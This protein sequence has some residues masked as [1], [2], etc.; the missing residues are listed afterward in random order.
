MTTTSKKKILIVGAGIAGLS[1]ARLC[2]RLN[3]AF[4]L[5]EKQPQLRVTGAGI[6]LPANA[7]KALRYLG[8]GPEID[9]EA[10]Q[11]KTIFYTK[12][13]GRILST[14]SL[15]EPPL[16]LDHFVAL[17]R[18]KLQEILIND[19][20]AKIHFDTTVTALTPSPNGLRVEFNS[21]HLTQEEYQAVIGADGL[22]SHI[23]ELSFGP[24][25]LVDLG[26]TNWRW[27]SA[28][29]TENLQPT[30]MLGAQDLFMAYPISSNSVYCYAH[31]YDPENK[32][33]Q[34]PDPQTLL[35]QIFKSYKGV[36]REFLENLPD[37]EALIPGRLRSVPHPFY[38]KGRVALVGDAGNA[39]SPMLQQ[40]AAC[41]LEDIIVLGELLAAFKTETALAYYEHYRKE[42]VDWIVQA[43]DRPMKTLV[44]MHALPAIIARNLFIRRKGPLNVQG[45]RKLLATD[46][47]AALPSFIA[48]MQTKVN[49]SIGGKH[50]V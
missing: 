19:L 42:R 26:V 16:N 34:H 39:C 5:I 20:P 46:P 33:G 35:R 43:S 21:P 22:N 6:A 1:L 40:G 13:S 28:F 14:A 18:K 44:K 24:I 50:V 30:Y 41:A 48:A 37:N 23:R 7:V 32:F 12:S 31:R 8:L 49:P 27:I 10:H 9:R 15:L 3:L 25:P 17:P 29:P 11:V 47:L 45:W 2:Q 38:T 4:T 36:A